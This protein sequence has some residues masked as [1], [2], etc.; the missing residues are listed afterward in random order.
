MRAKDDTPESIARAIKILKAA[1]STSSWDFDEQ[2]AMLARYAVLIGAK[3]KI[4]RARP[5][6]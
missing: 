5:Q 2:I 3:P 1:Q 4:K 6:S